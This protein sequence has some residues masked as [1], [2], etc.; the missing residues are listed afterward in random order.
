M[1]NQ[2]VQIPF[3]VEWCRRQ[4]PALRREADGSPVVYFDGPA[5]SQ[6]PARV[7]EAVANYLLYHNANHGGLFANSRE[8]DELLGRAHAAVADLLGADDPACVAFGPNMTTLTLALSRALG[9][10]WQTGDE[11]LVTEADHDANVTPWRLA[12]RDAGATVRHVRL[13]PEDCTLDLNDLNAKLSNRTRLVAI[14]AA[15]NAVGT[16]HP[17]QEIVDAAHAVGARVFVDAVH[18]APHRLIDVHQWDCD[19]LA[20]SAYKFF[21][22]H[23]GV[24]WGRR[25]LLEELPVYKLRPSPDA[26]PGR[27]M[28]GTQSHEAISGAAAAV[29]YL[30]D[31]GRHHEP[32]LRNRRTALEAAM[33]H[34]ALYESSLAEK[35]LAAMATLPA[36]KVWGITDP[37]RL[38]QRVPTFGLTHRSLSPEA[39]ATRLDASG[40]Y[41][42]HGNF[43]ALPLTEA[44]G[45]EPA[46][47]LRIGLLH[48][49]TTEEIDRLVDV[50]RDMGD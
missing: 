27:W 15:S 14:S 16:L 28:T 10:T 34:I 1:P 20:A 25:E 4:F 13:R 2:A 19:F 8:S 30:A 40:I 32:G 12:A 38:S 47:M 23:L 50:L 22:P 43:Y 7:S 49:N 48:Y 31:V 41:A 33:K 6:V 45:L 21:G 5:G 42:W 17:V 29:A 44:L 46:G 36:F 37:A 39:L 18:H 24:L 11:V 9:R 26:L 35:L 3:D